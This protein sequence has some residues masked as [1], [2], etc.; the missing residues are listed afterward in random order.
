[1]MEEKLFDDA[2]V[3]EVRKKI[4]SE[5]LKGVDTKELLVLIADYFNDEVSSIQ[6]MLTD[7]TSK[8]QKMVHGALGALWAIFGSIIASLIAGLVI[9]LLT[10]K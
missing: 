7:S 6:K 5:G 10:L 8:I 1:L 4:Q 2:V 9:A 3:E